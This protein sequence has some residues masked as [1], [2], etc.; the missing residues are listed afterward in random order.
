[1]YCIL[2]IDVIVAP[3]NKVNTVI[4]QIQNK[5]ADGH[6][7]GSSTLLSSFALPPKHKH[8]QMPASFSFF[9]LCL[10]LFTFLS[11]LSA[12][13]HTF[14]EAAL[15]HLFHFFCLPHFFHHYFHAR[16][17]LQRSLYHSL[18]YSLP[19][20]SLPT[21]AHTCFFL[22]SFF[23]GS[24][25]FPPSC[26]HVRTRANGTGRPASRTP[27]WAW[28][29]LFL[30]S[31]WAIWSA[32][33]LL[34]WSPASSRASWGWTHHLQAQFVRVKALLCVWWPSWV[35]SLSPEFPSSKEPHSTLMAPA[36]WVQLRG[37]WQSNWLKLLT[38][39]INS[40][41]SVMIMLISCPCVKRECQNLVKR[42]TIRWK[43]TTH[44]HRFEHSV[45]LQ[46]I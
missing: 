36:L 38:S 34:Y 23:H 4:K 6:R 28:T 41:H 3:D 39:L 10:T 20:H 17:P 29:A 30:W 35:K 13:T 22:S 8:S 42:S 31:F 24:F 16:E 43:Y 11:L 19:A 33:S 25:I 40:Y 32:M 7:T 46:L 21:H 26:I 9:I 44:L 2:C 15:H 12:S 27:S 45:R 18:S 5:P 37:R 1:M 14:A